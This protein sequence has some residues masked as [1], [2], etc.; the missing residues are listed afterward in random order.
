MKRDPNTPAKGRVRKYLKYA[1]GEILL[2]MIGILLAVQVN[3]WNEDRI[4]G[5][6]ERI[7]LHE[8]ANNLKQ[9]ISDLEYNLEDDGKTLNSI[10]DSKL[11]FDIISYY[12]DECYILVIVEKEFI[13]NAEND[14]IKPMK[15]KYFDFASSDGPAY[16]KDFEALLGEGSLQQILVQLKGNFLWKMELSE[17][18]LAKAQSLVSQINQYLGV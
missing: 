17:S 7:N 10:K 18:A 8:L 5:D 12:E 6:I 16:P 15:I 4:A 13:N 1:I 14:F 11:R 3:N 2:V 9:D